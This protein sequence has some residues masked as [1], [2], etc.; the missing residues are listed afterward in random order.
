MDP[1]KAIDKLFEEFIEPAELEQANTI[2]F[3]EDLLY[4]YRVN[5]YY[6]RN[7]NIFK[8]MTQDYV[9]AGKP[10]ISPAEAIY[11]T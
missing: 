10:R 9:K 7:E 3:K 11:F 4:N 1:A 6:E 8:K 2:Q 5:Q